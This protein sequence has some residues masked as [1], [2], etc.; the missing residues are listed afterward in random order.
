MITGVSEMIIIKILLIL[1]ASGLIV[2]LPGMIVCFGIDSLTDIDA[3][4]AMMAF[5]VITLIAFTL[6]A[7][8][9]LL[10]AALSIW[11]AV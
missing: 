7:V 10:V 3:D 11:M 4:R 2:G 5:L 8:V 1:I 6:F 9:G